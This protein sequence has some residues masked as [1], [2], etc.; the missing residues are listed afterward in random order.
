MTL[1]PLRGRVTEIVL[2]KEAFGRWL[3]AATCLFPLVPEAISNA[4]LSRAGPA[5]QRTNRRAENRLKG[6]KIIAPSQG[7][8]QFTLQPVECGIGGNNFVDCF[9][10]FVVS[11]T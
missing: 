11:K 2:K 7:Q 1:L 4:S 10:G 8:L 9:Y 3:D 6:L 5:S